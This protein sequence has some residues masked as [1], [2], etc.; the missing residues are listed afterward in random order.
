[1]KSIFLYLF[2]T[3]LFFSCKKNEIGNAINGTSQSSNAS[4]GEKVY[5]I[6]NGIDPY[7][8]KWS[9][10]MHAARVKNGTAKLFMGN[11]QI[12][13]MIYFNWDATW[14]D[15]L[16]INRGI[17]GTTWSE[18]IPYYQQLIY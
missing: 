9:D 15:S 4:L 17:G 8:P 12:E 18:K 6:K 11:S 7:L 16:G 1:M 13:R 10:T 3:L 14:R 5:D 2:L